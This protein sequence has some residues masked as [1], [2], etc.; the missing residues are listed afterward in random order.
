[1]LVWE[2]C[3]MTKIEIECCLSQSGKAIQFD[4]ENAGQIKLDFDSSQASEAIKLLTMS[5]KT[6]KVRIE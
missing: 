6:F 1:M 3:K 5:G 2:K 4:S